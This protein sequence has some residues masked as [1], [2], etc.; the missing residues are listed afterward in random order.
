M[1]KKL[2]SNSLIYAIGPQIPK[3]ASIFLLPFITAN[4]TSKDYGVWGLVGTYTAL[5]SGL[6]DLGLAQPMVN[7]FF[8]Y[9]NT[10]KPIWS[11]FYGFLLV[12]SVP[13][14]ILQALILWLS[15]HLMVGVNIYKII[16]VYTISHLYFQL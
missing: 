11:S 14:S 9:P 15:L 8:K 3:I 5:L 4:L 10:W 2:F 7:V 12:W 13:F 1:I 16:L 6:R